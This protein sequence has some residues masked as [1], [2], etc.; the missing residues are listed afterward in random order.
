MKKTFYVTLIA[1]MVT[2][3]LAGFSFSMAWNQNK[4]LTLSEREQE[5]Y[6]L[7]CAMGILNIKDIRQTSLNKV[8][9]IYY[10]SK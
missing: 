4:I 6:R 5:L 3:F 8:E 10:E 7:Q 2:C 9:I 1:L